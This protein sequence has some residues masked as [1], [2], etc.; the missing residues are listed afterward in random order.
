MGS[1]HEKRQAVCV[2]CGEK[3]IG[4]G[5]YC[6]ACVS[7]LEDERK[8]KKRTRLRDAKRKE[9]APAAPPES[10]EEKPPISERA[11]RTTS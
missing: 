1:P 10:K 2:R 8:H 4:R 3:M 6:P 9:A 7:M 11:E 5:Q